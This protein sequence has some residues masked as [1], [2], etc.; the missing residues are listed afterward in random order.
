MVSKEE[1]NVQ[2][3]NIHVVQLSS[4]PGNPSSTANLW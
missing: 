4:P 1:V 3:E 2:M